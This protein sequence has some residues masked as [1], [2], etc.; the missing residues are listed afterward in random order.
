MA[1]AFFKQF[2]IDNNL[3]IDYG[4]MYG[5]YRDFYISLK[6]TLGSSKILNIITNIGSNKEQLKAVLSVFSEDE[7]PMY[8]IRDMKKTDTY[9]QF[10]FELPS[11][12][13]Q[14]IVDFINK[15]I[16]SYI[17]NNLKVETICPICHKALNNEKVSIVDVAGILTPIHEE[18]VEKG[19]KE[20]KEKAVL[21]EKEN[22]KD[23]K[24][25]KSG[26]LG[27]IIFGLIY[28]LILMVSFFFVQ[29]ILENSSSADN[30]FI[31]I[32]QYAPV[33]VA[34]FA[35]PIVYAGYDIFK[36]RK[37]TGKYIIILWVVIISTLLGTFF[38]FV[39][40]L[41]VLGTGNT[42]LELLKLVGQLITCKDISGS[43]RSFRWG[44]YI[45]IIFALIL[46]ILS[47]VFKFSNKKEME[48][49]NNDT[50]EK[51]D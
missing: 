40:S 10:T 45:Y 39:S 22:N 17:A 27:A 28:M 19:K 32:F 11:D 33:L 30:S 13:L 3:T 48:E 21:K 42:F 37:G 18:C 15:F 44:F 12:H 4:Y 35:C 43:T 34:L 26:L 2:A 25:Y 23:T 51:L 38:G 41:L 29:F 31:L 20:A 16:D 7:L 47:M 14:L 49:A 9:L 8:C 1:S 46:A 36:G 6:E 50:F 5:K 24:G